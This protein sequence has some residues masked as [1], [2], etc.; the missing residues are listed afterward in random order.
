MISVVIIGYG[1][2][3]H[4]LINAFS[5]AKKVNLIQIYNRSIKKIE[6]L[7]EKKNITNNL[8]DL[9]KANIYIISVSDDAIEEVSSKIDIENAFV[10]HTSGATSIQ[11]LKNTGRKGV[12]YMLQSFSKNKKVDFNKIPF[13]LETENKADLLLLEELASSIGKKIYHISSEQRKQLHVAAVFVNNFTNHLYKIGNDIC[14]K[15]G[16][17]FEI[18]YPLIKETASKVENLSPI[19]AQTGP[20]KRNDGKTIKNHLDLLNTEQQTIYKLLTQSIQNG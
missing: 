14:K 12:F 1:N 18:L 3:A 19:E 4:H 5:E 6:H 2:V 17:P 13:C 15:N 9:K 8:Q 16:I 7:K 20:A 11:K 10:V